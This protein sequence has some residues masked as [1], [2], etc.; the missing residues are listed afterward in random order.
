MINTHSIFLLLLFLSCSRINKNSSSSFNDVN[1]HNNNVEYSHNVWISEEYLN[2]MQN[3]LPNHCVLQLEF[4]L[5]KYNI[6]DSKIY[7]HDYMDNIEELDAKIKG[8]EYFVY[9]DISSS[10]PFCSF[11]IKNDSLLLNTS[12]VMHLYI[13]SPTLYSNVKFDI[14]IG[15]LNIIL[16]YKL[17][18]N[19]DFNVFQKLNITDSTFIYCNNELGKVN[20]ISTK[21]DCT[22]MWILELLSKKILVYKYLNSCDPKSSPNEIKKKLIFTINL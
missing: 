14:N 8:K 1:N 22:N 17:L 3:N 6:G 20:L 21:D 5:L 13:N 4:P 16:F 11:S 10:A 18:K 7:F 9:K 12:G 2:C 15:R 19:G